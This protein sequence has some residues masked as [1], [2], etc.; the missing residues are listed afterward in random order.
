MPS[1]GCFTLR[2]IYSYG[3]VLLVT[4]IVSHQLVICC[5]YLGRIMGD[6]YW[7]RMYQTLLYGDHTMNGSIRTSGIPP[8]ANPMLGRTFEYNAA[9]SAFNR[10]ISRSYSVHS[11][12]ESRRAGLQ[13]VCIVALQYL[14]VVRLPAINLKLTVMRSRLACSR[15]RNV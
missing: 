1:D 11:V 12:Q 5:F 3:L 2:T 10:R 14:P 7:H 9:P 13:F 4:V 8:Q 6:D 15:T